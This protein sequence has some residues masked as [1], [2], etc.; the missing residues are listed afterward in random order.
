M[1]HRIEQL[2]EKLRFEETI[3]RIE[4]L[5]KKMQIS[6]LSNELDKCKIKIE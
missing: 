5:A 1:S 2:T 3:L 6:E 4:L